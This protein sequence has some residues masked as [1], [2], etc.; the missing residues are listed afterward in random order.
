MNEGETNVAKKK[1]QQQ[2]WNDMT[3]DFCL[4]EITE[5][6]NGISLCISFVLRLNEVYLSNNRFPLLLS[7]FSTFHARTC[8]YA[9]DTN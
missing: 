1:K 6:L 3:N 4:P 5:H 8:T 9:R 2:Q 7:H